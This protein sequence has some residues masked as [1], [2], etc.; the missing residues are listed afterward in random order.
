CARADG[1]GLVLLAM[2]DYW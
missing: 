1:M 2:M